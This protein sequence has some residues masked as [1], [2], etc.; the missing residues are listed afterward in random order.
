MKDWGGGGEDGK[1]A[2]VGAQEGERTTSNAT[3]RT[4]PPP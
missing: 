3:S 2:D 1:G 4:S